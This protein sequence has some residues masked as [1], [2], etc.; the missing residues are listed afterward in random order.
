MTYDM[1]ERNLQLGVTLHSHADTQEYE[2]RIDEIS[3]NWHAFK[4]GVFAEYKPSPVWTVRL[5]ARDIAQTAAYRDRDVYA[6]LR[7]AASLAFV[8]RRSLSNGAMLGINIQ[9]DF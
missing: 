5:F 3:T 8:E 7:G 2:Y 4:L 9:H 6:G 1:P